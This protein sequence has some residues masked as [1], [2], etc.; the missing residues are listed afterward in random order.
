MIKKTLFVFVLLMLLYIGWIR[1]VMPL[2]KVV[3]HQWQDNEIKAQNFLYQE[4]A[5]SKN[6]I[7]GSSLS[8]RILADSLAGFT[9]LALNGQSIFD[10]LNI[11]THKKD[12]PEKVFIEMNVVI[13]GE[14]KTFTDNLFNPVLFTMREDIPA[15]R[16]GYQPL[17]LAGRPA[18]AFVRTALSS[19]K[20]VLVRKKGDPAGAAA[21]TAATT[22]TGASTAAPIAAGATTGTTTM[23]PTSTA[24]PVAKDGNSDLFTRLITI[25]ENNYSRPADSAT[26]YRNLNELARYVEALRRRGVKVCFYEMPIDPHLCELPLERSIREGFYRVFPPEKN[27]YIPHP[28]CTGY[29]TSD[30]LHLKDPDAIRYTSYLKSRISS[31]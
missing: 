3:Q 27:S 22:P 23:T 21:A 29:E 4:G 15:L 5:N 8:C 18:A 12:L 25:Q 28:D 14:N 31:L 24:T 26:L 9:N 7:V 2:N 30:G 19:I 17:G 10:G 13:R 1:M 20:S 11:I 16:D 6:V